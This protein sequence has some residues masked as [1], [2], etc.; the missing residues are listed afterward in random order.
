M[1][2]DLI[3]AGFIGA[4]VGFIFGLPWGGSYLS[5]VA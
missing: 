1:I 4:T 5:D 2:G 3:I